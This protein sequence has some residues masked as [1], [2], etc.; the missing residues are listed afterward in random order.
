[1]ANLDSALIGVVAALVQLLVGLALAMGSVFIGLKMYDRLTEG[2]D[3]WAEIK[4]GNV[5]VGIVMAAVIFAI[6]N[7][8]QSGVVQIT[9]GLGANQ[10]V[11]TM[12]TALIIGFINLAIG[13]V[14]AVVSVWIAIKVLDRITTDIEEMEELAKGNVAVAIVMAGVLVA[15]SFVIGSAVSGISNALNP[16]TLGL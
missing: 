15:V 9:S 12:V 1:M 4:K 13:L 10:E 8:V 7:V 2:V 14:A 5:A 16:R 6:A 11:G 3:E